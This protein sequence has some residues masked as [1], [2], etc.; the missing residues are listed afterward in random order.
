M[1]KISLIFPCLI[2]VLLS[3]SKEETDS[4][5][6]NSISTTYEFSYSGSSNSTTIGVK[7]SAEET[8][9]LELSQPASVSFNE[10]ILIMND[11]SRVYKNTYNGF[12]DAG[13]C[14]YKDLDDNV[15]T[16]PVTLK[17]I[18]LPYTDTIHKSLDY[19]FEWV[20]EAVSENETVVVTI[21]SESFHQEFSTNVVGATNLIL[22]ATQLQ[23]L[24]S[25]EADLVVNRDFTFNSLVEGT[26]AGGKIITRYTPAIVSIIINN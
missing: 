5:S 26:G 15:F 14:I 7:F 1:K 25:G 20:G 13:T 23:N 17:S 8:S 12:V 4:I 9:F 24:T 22:P 21:Y 3:C 19:N 18:D 6:Q 11:Q 2:G 16:N 10:D